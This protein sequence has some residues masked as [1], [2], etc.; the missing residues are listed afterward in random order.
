MRE[1]SLDC[2]VSG[3]VVLGGEV[4]A[5]VKNSNRSAI[6]LEQQVRA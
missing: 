6:I 5:A 2:P 3:D 1:A 4:A